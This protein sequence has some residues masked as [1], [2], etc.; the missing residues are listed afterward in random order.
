[1]HMYVCTCLTCARAAAQFIGV[2]NIFA[3]VFS[4]L[5][6]VGYAG[7]SYNL[8]T[9]C[10]MVMSIGFC[11]AACKTAAKPRSGVPLDGAPCVW[12]TRR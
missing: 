11:A 4:A 9:L 6:F 3:V 1:M 10:V 8:I 7:F 12:P 2:T 5:G